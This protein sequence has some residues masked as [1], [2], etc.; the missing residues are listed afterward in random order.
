MSGII[1]GSILLIYIFIAYLIT[2]GIVRFFQKKYLFKYL[3]I[4]FLIFPFWD[5]LVAKGIAST[6]HFLFLQPVVYEMPEK[7]KEGKYDSL[8]E[9]LIGTG[10]LNFN[11]KELIKMYPNIRNEVSEFIELSAYQFK[12]HPFEKDIERVLLRVYLNT[13][14]F[15]FDIIDKS[16]ARFVQK[17]EK[18]KIID[19]WLLNIQIKNLIILDTKKNKTLSKTSSIYVSGFKFMN[20]IRENVFIWIMGNTQRAIFQGASSYSKKRLKK[21]IF[22]IKGL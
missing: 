12:T 20:W 9:S 10:G 18:E 11:E 3:F 16:K 1:I 13:D 22:K 6:Y 2:K 4:G 19:F 8:G 7:N 17:F 5:L 21:E 15:K 14:K